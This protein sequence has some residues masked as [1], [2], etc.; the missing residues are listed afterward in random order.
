MLGNSLFLNIIKMLNQT[1]NDDT[2][3]KI[4]VR[5][6]PKKFTYITPVK[7]WAHK[8]GMIDLRPYT[9]VEIT[10]TPC[11]K[12]MRAPTNILSEPKKFDWMGNK[13]LFVKK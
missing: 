10:L 2:I 3:V 1:Q 12:N 9:T 8:R 7:K 4:I 6:Q 5:Y 13:I 11:G